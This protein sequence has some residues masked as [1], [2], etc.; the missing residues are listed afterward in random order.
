MVLVSLH[1]DAIPVLFPELCHPDTVIRF[2]QHLA[3]QLT[4]SDYVL[5]ISARVDRDL[6]EIAR[7]FAGR[8]VTSEVIPLGA[9][10]AAGAAPLSDVA[11]R[12]AFPEL[13]GLRF[14]LGVGTVEPRKNHGLLLDAFDRLEAPDAGLVIVGRQG[15][16]AEELIA[17]LKAHPAYGKR[18]FW[19]EGLE[20]AGLAGALCPR[21]RL[22]VS[23]PL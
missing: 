17:R 14:M 4:Y 23:L 22:R 12:A 15:W 3:H 6:K 21:L 19:H 1:Y 11:F 16:M 18:L 20:D 8:S 5:T 9:D 13:D 2:A 10:L 7:R